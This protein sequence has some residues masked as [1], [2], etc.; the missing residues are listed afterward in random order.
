MAGFDWAIH[1][2]DTRGAPTPTCASRSSTNQQE[3]NILRDRFD[4]VEGLSGWMHND[5]LTGREDVIGA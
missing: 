4:L 5:M 1:K 2:G 3:A